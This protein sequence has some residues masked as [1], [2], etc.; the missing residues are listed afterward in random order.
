LVPGTGRIGSAVLGAI[1]LGFEA[2]DQLEVV[3]TSDGVQL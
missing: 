3:V 2:C 1:V